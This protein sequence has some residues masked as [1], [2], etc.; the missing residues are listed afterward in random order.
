MRS[1]ETLC[2]AETPA[3]RTSAVEVCAPNEASIVDMEG[4][5]ATIYEGSPS[6]PPHPAGWDPLLFPQASVS[7]S[8]LAS[9]A[10]LPSFAGTLPRQGFN[11]N[12][13]CRR[14]GEVGRPGR[15]G[16]I[17]LLRPGGDPFEDGESANAGWPAPKPSVVADTGAAR[18]PA[19]RPVT[20]WQLSPRRCASPRTSW[21]SAREF[22]SRP[23]P[24]ASASGLLPQMRHLSGRNLTPRL[25]TPR[26]LNLGGPGQRPRPPVPAKG[27]APAGVGLYCK[28]PE[29]RV[30]GDDTR[31]RTPRHEGSADFDRRRPVEFGEF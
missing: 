14:G 4:A 21:T 23:L 8:S 30:L 27:A 9:L 17:R 11:P 15:A 5:P 18:R 3:V 1:S 26:R 2:V 20:G 19:S 22:Y 29:A 12:S 25:R 31:T 13:V 10:S 24:T 28:P 7:A 6:S 16:E